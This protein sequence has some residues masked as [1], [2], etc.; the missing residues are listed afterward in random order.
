MEVTKSLKARER[1]QKQNQDEE[2]QSAE[3][4][5]ERVVLCPSCNKPAT[6]FQGKGI[7]CPHCGVYVPREN[8]NQ[9][10]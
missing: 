9:G 10:D 2:K 7:Y 8:V 3:K 4:K 6:N 5:K 1:E